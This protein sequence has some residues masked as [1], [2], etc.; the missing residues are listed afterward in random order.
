MKNMLS[1]ILLISIL[2]SGCSQEEFLKNQTTNLPKITAG[3]E[4][5]ESRTYIEEGN[6]LRWSENDQISFFYKS[7]LNLQYKFDGET[8]DNV[9][10][11]SPVNQAIDTRN[12]LSHNYAIYPYA[13]DIKITDSGV[14]TS[15]LPAE[16]SYA[17]NSFGLGDNTMVAVTQNTND[18]FLKFKNVCG[19]LKLQLYGDDVTVKSITLKGNNNEKLAGKAMITP[20]YGNAPTISM[21]DDAT[22][23][24]T[25]DCG[26]GVKIGTTAETAT[27]FWMVVPPTTFESGFEV[28]ITDIKGGSFTQSTSNKI[29]IVRNT[30]KPM[31]ALETVIQ[32]DE[33]IPY[34]TFTAAAE[35]TLTMSRSVEKLEYSVD[36]KKWTALGTNK[37]T[38]GGENGTLR[39]RG[40]SPFGTAETQ[41]MVGAALYGAN[42]IFGNKNI[43]V[44]CKGDIRTLIDW[45]NY[46]T[47]DTSNARFYCLFKDCKNLT[48]APELPISELATY[49]YSYMFENCISL[50]TPPQLS[51]L[52]LHNSCYEGMFKGCT[53]LTVTPE[54]PATDLTYNCYERMFEGC[55]SITSAP[56]LNAEDISWSCYERMF[57]DCIN[58]QTPPELP[59]RNM[60]VYCYCSMFE[61]C[62]NLTTAPELPAETLATRCYDSMFKGCVKL[63]SPPALP[64]T[65][66]KE[67][68][69]NSMF[70]GCVNLKTAPELPGEELDSQCYW[71]M[72]EGCTSLTK[73]PSSLP[74]TRL[75]YACYYRMFYGCT[76]LTE[77]PVLPAKNLASTCY[78]SMFYGC[79]S[80][81]KAPELPAT[82][83]ADIC[84]SSMFSGCTS[85]TEAPVLPAETLV[86][87]CYSNMFNGC[88]NLSKITMLATNTDDYQCL[89]NWVEGVSSTGTFT[90]AKEMTTLPKGS[91]G[92]PS[93]WT[94]KNYSVE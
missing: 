22:E 35:Q 62:I 36:N 70:Q 52:E 11:F 44:A 45:S 30:I 86:D 20:I 8:G 18:T 71:G 63:Q 39:L 5:N 59:A 74:A 27:A 89:N 47:V 55:T 15:N 94:T 9:G 6:L 91:S 43:A 19:Y 66:I 29:S 76:S 93:G 51:A 28:T 34:L 82:K 90:K 32:G 77:A 64:A 88:Q 92:I 60:Q 12:S 13:S 42:V 10:T 24:I 16:Q 81:T 41:P 49:C 83:L 37:V 38:F 3:F 40:Q 53:A 67:A 56:E 72:F 48:S 23:T 58:L 7:T 85:L 61:G 33:D 57:K 78:G 84:Y 68:C 50:T 26:E 1:L 79:T 25:L 87:R 31:Y 65:I 73:A 21:A 2:V 54:L 75:D 69:Y 14:I 17:S 46:S 80:L 4:Q